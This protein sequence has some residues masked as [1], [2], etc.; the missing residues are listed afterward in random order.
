MFKRSL[1]TKNRLIFTLVSAST[2][3]GLTYYF[4]LVYG[5]EF[6]YEAYLYHLVRKDNRHNY[7]VYWYLIYHI[8]EAQTSQLL[9]VLLFIPQ[10]GLIILTG[11]LFYY[12]IF[13]AVFV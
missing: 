12:D 5:Y 11:I 7:S 9:S 8:Y 6:L 2:F 13:F 10:W 1:F 4:Y 3:L